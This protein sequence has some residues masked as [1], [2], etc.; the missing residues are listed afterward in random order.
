MANKIHMDWLPWDSLKEVGDYFTVKGYKDTR[1]ISIA[2]HHQSIKLKCK[3]RTITVYG[4]D[5]IIRTLVILVYK[6]GLKYKNVIN[7]AYPADLPA[8]RIYTEIPF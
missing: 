5:R 4:E 2:A 3:F 8:G 7:F 1:K 6:E